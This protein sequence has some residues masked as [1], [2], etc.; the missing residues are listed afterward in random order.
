MSDWWAP[1][2]A[3]SDPL[4]TAHARATER[5]A[6]P[7][8]AARRLVLGIVGVVAAASL[9]V[10]AGWTT[11]TA[12]LQRLGPSG[13]TQIVPWS[14]VL[15][16][17]L[18]SSLGAMALGRTSIARG[19]SIATVV[20]GLT[21]LIAGESS[22]VAEALFGD[23]L[24]HVGVSGRPLVAGL[25]VMILLAVSLLADPPVRVARWTV[26]AIDLAIISACI[27]ALCWSAYGAAEGPALP[28]SSRVSVPMIVMVT[29][30]AFG[31]LALRPDVPPIAN[32][33]RQTLGGALS[34]GI[35]ST[36]VAAPFVVG[37]LVVAGPE[38]GW[39]ELSTGAVVL[40]FLTFIAVFA[41]AV[42]VARFSDRVTS[43]LAESEARFRLALEH[44]PIGIALV[45]TEGTWL[46]VNPA[47][48]RMFG[49]TESELRALTWQEITHPDDLAADQALVDETLAGQINGYSIEKRYFRNDGSVIWGLLSVGLVRDAAGD[50]RYFI[51]QIE[52]ITE[53]RAAE[54]RLR[55]LALHDS[56]TDLPNR[57][58]FMGRLDEV[59]GATRGPT[60]TIAVLY[61]DLDRFKVVNDSLGHSAGDR[62]LELV[63][64][65]IAA[66]TRPG[67]TVARLGGD[68]FAVLCTELD[69]LD[70]AIAIA[71]RLLQS[72]GEPLVV[73]GREVV[74]TASVG[75][76][77]A[78]PNETSE[79]LL[80]NA[81]VAMYQ[82]KQRGRH[83]VEVF[84][85][86][87]GAIAHSRFELE[88]AIR[89]ALRTDQFVVHYQ[90]Q[91][92]LTT[93][94]VVGVE[95]LVR[96]HHPERGLLAP[97]AFL[98]V[99]EELGLI[100]DIGARV[101]DRA[102]DECA[103]WLA[104]ED[105]TLGLAVNITPAQLSDPTFADVLLAAL[106]RYD[107]DPSQLCLEMTETSLFTTTGG[108]AEALRRLD[109]RQ[110][111]IAADDF[112][113]GY[114]SLAVLTQLPVSLLKID[115]SFTAAIADSASSH[116]AVVEAIIG[117]GRQLGID[118]IAEGVETPEQVAELLSL[119]CRFGQG[120]HFHRPM[121]A[122]E[123][124]S[125]L[126]RR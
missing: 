80:R 47:L 10:L 64:R 78:R 93:G 117:L 71:H 88:A 98:P 101:L 65:R 81:D 90:T 54:A 50:P 97:G 96:W 57:D 94:A 8:P 110:I 43:A 15:L 36:L 23:T 99:A 86:T 31:R 42:L 72:V 124:R 120:F 32:L 37:L 85:D 18:A 39:W 4:T 26:G 123:L 19:A 118:V 38:R 83:R 107:L 75:I 100:A 102:L 6:H 24:R 62:L 103:A 61:L 76:A 48:T 121:P 40:V 14:A 46:L 49:Y 91:H 56:L 28:D 27:A 59:L 44:A 77:M 21:V 115:H 112:G 53:R 16:L 89:D 125:T 58:L 126:A 114:A 69:S 66:I 45:G 29:A 13:H 11:D 2:I 119:G 7:S 73:A 84:S 63:A 52:D 35:L 82:A 122:E 92:D 87:L 30:L 74:T 3:G 67:D 108:A 109:A 113:T 68:E 95:A 1:A 55:A 22:A 12:S 70:T 25:V 111:R 33:R 105:L 9:V 104:T 79:N 5:D 20:I 41:G 116:H 51:S 106:E 34:R 60:P 17:L